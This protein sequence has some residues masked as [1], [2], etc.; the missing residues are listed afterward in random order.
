MRKKKFTD[1]TFLIP[2]RQD[3][4]E[5]LENIILVTEFLIENFKT[6]IK[7]FECAPYNNGLLE[8][9][10]DKSIQYDFLE[11][12]DPILFRTKYINQMVR[13]AET[14]FVSIWD[15]DAI[16][17][18][19]QIVKALE[20]LR[21]GEADFVYPYE[22]QFLDTSPIFRKLYVQ[23]RK[24]EILEQNM[25]K[26][27]EMYP[28]NPVG[29]GFLASLKA[30]KEVGIENENF[31]GWGLED[32][33]RYYRWENLG[34]KVKRVAGMMFHISHTRGLNSGFH[35]ADQVYIKN[36]EITRVIRSK[37][38]DCTPMNNQQ[39]TF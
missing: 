19:N 37:S 25:K 18:I 5:R 20:L 39:I 28:P 32:G 38:V 15:I 36:K 22:K 21:S 27:K 14:P 34:Y 3:S 33:E 11:D 9:L 6:N 31:Y 7:V 1:L 23:E 16:A 10:L 2:F 30:Y 35:N 13:E 8:K 12:N 26:L 24:I 17:P 29:G 4:L